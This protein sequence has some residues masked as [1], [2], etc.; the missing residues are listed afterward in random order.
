[1]PAILT[2][3]FFGRDLIAAAHMHNSNKTQAVQTQEACQFLAQLCQNQAELDAFLLGNQGPDPLFYLQLNYKYRTLNK[4][5]SLM[6]DDK[7]EEQLCAFI[8]AQ[9]K[10]SSSFEQGVA[11][12]YIAGF[13]AHYTLDST[14]HPL[15]YFWQYALTSAGVEGLD[16]SQEWSVHSHIE[17]EF[18]T[19]L[20]S[21]KLHAS[22]EEY[23][24]YEQV[25]RGSKQTLAVIDKLYKAL[26]GAVFD[27]AIPHNL[28][29]QALLSFRR[30]QRLLY[31]PSDDKRAF[32]GGLEESLR[33]QS[34]YKAL[35]HPCKLMHESI[36]SCEDGLTWQHPYAH[37]QHQSS[38]FDLYDEALSKYPSNLAFLL[39]TFKGHEDLC[40]SSF[41]A[42]TKGLD[43]SGKARF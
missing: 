4:L 9:A 11:R 31:A 7:I 12:A 26:E 36:F 27:C 42:L 15:V 5:G 43:F 8:H 18:D 33:S 2:H 19:V 13:L 23:K 37:T 22:I 41:R 6:H 30:I 21:R 35:S 14:A 32:I 24:P 28:F 40:A 39:D 1:M 3:D 17:T 16:A 25:L 34:L 38:F 29:T 20:L 10:L